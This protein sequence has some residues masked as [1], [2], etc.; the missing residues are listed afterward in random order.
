MQTSRRVAIVVPELGSDRATFSL[1]HVRPGDHVTAGDRVAEVLIPGAIYDVGAP[2][3]GVLVE[4]TAQPGDPLAPGQT[5]G[6][7]EE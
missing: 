7:I 5:I 1:W 6:E 3:S 4:R 2:A